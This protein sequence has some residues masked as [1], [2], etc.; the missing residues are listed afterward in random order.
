MSVLLAVGLA[1]LG[2]SV[3]GMARG[4]QSLDGSWQFALDRQ[5]T[6]EAEKWFSSDVL[7][8]D[9]SQ[10]T[11]QVPGSW[12]AQ[13]FGDETDKVH[14]LFYGKGWYR[15]TV[16]V[17]QDWAGKRLF[18][19]IGGVHRYAKVWVNEQLLGEHIGYLSP[20]EYEVT[21]LIQPG[22]EDVITI[23]V[24]SAQRHEIDTLTGCFDLIDYM[25][26]YWGGI[27]GHVTLEARSDSYLKDLFISPRIDPAGCE[28]RAALVGNG[29]GCDAVRLEVQDAEGATVA[30]VEKAL[31]EALRD[32][33]TIALSVDMPGAA[34]W[35][36]DAPTLYRA[37]LSLLK[38]GTAVDTVTDRFG[39][40]TIEI[41]GKRVLLNG[42]PVF[43]RGYGDDCV[44][45]ETMAAP[46]DENVYLDRLRIAKEFGFNHVRHHSHLLPP[47]YYEACDEVGM[48]VSAEFPI[49]YQRF[50]DAASDA[51]LNLYR[52][53]WTA[54]IKRFRN[55]PSIMDW[56]MGNELYKGIPIAPELHR[57]AKT[58]DPTRPV[59]DSDGV[60]PGIVG[61]ERLD[62]DTLDLFFT[63]FD[64][65]AN[66]LGTPNKFNMA[67]PRKP[68]VSHETGNYVT[69]P[70][71]DMID[72]FQHNFKPFWLL[73]TREKLDRLGLL[74]ESDL[75]ARNSERLYL[76]CHKT[77]IEAIRKNSD[78]SG[79]H[80]WLLQD[81]WTTSNGLVDAYFRP[82]PGISMDDVRRFNADVV[83]LQDGLDLTYRAG[84]RVD[85]AIL[86]SN[87][88]SNALPP[89][90]VRW[91]ATANGRVVAEGEVQTKT[92]A[93]AELTKVARM[94]LVAPDVTAPVRLDVQVRFDGGGISCQNEWSTWVY[95]AEPGVSNSDVPV[96][97]AADVFRVCSAYGAEPVPQDP[98]P[99][100]AVYVASLFDETLVEAVAGG[101]CALLIRPPMLMPIAPMQFKT[102]W[103]HGHAN[104]NNAG[105]VVYDHP[106]TRVMAPEGWCD[107]GWCR[108]ING[109]D[110]YIL[111]DAPFSPE[112]MVRGV[113]VLSVCR[114]K[115]LMFQARVGKGSIIVCGLNLDARGAGVE[116]FVPEAE[117]LTAQLIKH[118]QTMPA[119]DAEIPIDFLESRAQ[120][121][122]SMNGPFVEGFARL[123]RNEGEQS[124]WFSYRE[125]RAVTYI[126]RQTSLGHRVEWETAPIP[127]VEDGDGVTIVFSGGLGWISEPK[128][129]GFV[130]AVNEND[131]VSFDVCNGIETWRNDE[132]GVS[133][134]L[135]PKR[136]TN[137]D[138]VGLFYLRLP[139]GMVDPGKPCTLSVRSAAKN[140]QRW[141]AL[142]PYTDVLQPD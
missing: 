49:A 69:F 132:R 78:I 34:L 3:P 15:K 59:V 46:S 72:L 126:C 32:A 122:P 30:R 120:T 14:H 125:D 73:K 17:P 91:T 96:Y 6:G 115:A 116:A 121:M 24:D 141:F 54:V 119:P 25:D 39:L 92:V 128:T 38:D 66:P 43:L 27:W 131:A 26:T 112:V 103:W 139:A 31:S 81:Y 63:Q 102:A 118:A 134:T 123:V 28:V 44:Y 90:L 55:H 5:G 23:C 113:E 8:T 7:L 107:A 137:E 130:L 29:T 68:V 41:G 97:A 79:Y 2:A 11:I 12:D 77:N 98:L 47:E 83:L 50:H 42:T 33:H 86:V 1:L 127:E 142:H 57:I 58:L 110:G 4:V 20:F 65:F 75:W 105:T 80:W 129:E 101:A 37:C 135:L 70:R 138:N 140:S 10:D 9:A 133:L 18:L 104:D 22:A 16:S 114:D 61:S 94:D 19:C 35:T 64:V 117:W 62:R 95:P 56:C 74:N 124:A 84:E 82:K 51:A 76:L 53:E 40:R 106:A 67:T 21:A 111:D 136:A 52:Q 71:L 36:P 60:W 99:T 45:P 89:G 87:F 108:L 93:Q 88:A 13:G 85:A 100:K 109:A 48:L